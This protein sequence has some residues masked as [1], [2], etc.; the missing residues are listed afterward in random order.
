MGR[1]QIINLPCNFLVLEEKEN[2]E[3]CQYGLRKKY[4]VLDNSAIWNHDHDKSWQS[5]RKAFVLAKSMILIGW[6]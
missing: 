6:P 4:K 5:W 3:S 1:R 2:I